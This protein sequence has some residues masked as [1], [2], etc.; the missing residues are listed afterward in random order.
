MC[1][2]CV[3]DFNVNGEILSRRVCC[4]GPVIDL[5]EALP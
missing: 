2:C 3:R 4:D 1:F 5:M